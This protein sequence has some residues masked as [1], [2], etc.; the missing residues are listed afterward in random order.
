MAETF[1]DYLA[2]NDR[3][4]AE[5]L[6]LSKNEALK[7]GLERLFSLPLTSR[8]ALVSLQTKFPEATEIFVVGRDQHIRIIEAI[9]RR[10]GSRAES[11]AREHALIARR[12]LE[13][14]LN[15]E[16]ILTELPGSLLL[17][18]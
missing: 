1:P 2:M 17:R 3:F 10:Q 4:H 16:D 18:R 15:H 9:S 5:V 13:V 14:A 8:H 6:R 11:I 12:A 7:H